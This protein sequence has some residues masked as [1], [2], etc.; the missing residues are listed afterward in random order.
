[1]SRRVRSV[2]AAVSPSS[3]VVFWNLKLALT[4]TL[5]AA[6]AG[7]AAAIAPTPPPP[8]SDNPLLQ[9]VAVFGKDERTPLTR[10][11]WSL[12]ARIGVLHDTRS[13]TVCTAFCVAPDVVATAA[14]CLYRPG[15][16]TPTRLSD[17]TVRLHGGQTTSR[18]AGANEEA[19]ETNVLVG[20]TRLNVKP[21]IDATRDWALIRLAEPLCKNGTFKL[22]RRPVEDVMRLARKGD[23][24][25]VAYHRDVPKWEPMISRYC[26]VQR[27]F[28]DVDWP[29]VRRDFADPEQLLLHTCDTGGASSGSPLLADG[30]D[31]PEVV[32]I[33]VGTYVQSKVIMLNGEVVH[34]FRSDDVANTGV[35]SQAFAAA[36]DA[37]TS[38]DLIASR[39]EIRRL[40]AALAERGFYHGAKNGRF[41]AETKIAIQS[42]ERA[43]ALPVTGLATTQLMHAL[44]G[45]SDVVTG[46]IPMEAHAEAPHH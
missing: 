43:A 39:T 16:A 31:G 13:H 6:L 20:S 26:Q 23:V 17:L 14:H 8:Q 41:G 9:R 7:P 28:P 5:G 44:L 24:Y 40:Q 34:R 33:N 36:F 12:G 1:M 46:R 35:N 42:F 45:E 29:T 19:A 25:N 2:I 3:G 30:P 32:G 15:D 18:V 37:F 27:S 22:S 38:A 11:D 21:P 10:A 4:L